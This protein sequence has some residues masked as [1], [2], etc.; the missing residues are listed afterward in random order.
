MIVNPKVSVIMPSLNSISY[1]KESINS[2][3]NQTL[4]EI[5]II[6]VDAGSTDGTYEFLK[7]CAEIDNRIKVMYSQKKSYGHQMNMA[8]DIASGEYI[9]IVETD[10]FIQANMYEYLYKMA[11]DN[12][13]DFIKAD[14]YRF[15]I[16][17][18]GSMNK[19]LQH[20]YV[21]KV[22]YN[23]VIKPSEEMVTFRFIMNTWSGIY[24]RKFLQDNMIRHNDT[25]GASFQD[26]GFWFQTFVLAERAYFVDQPFYM[27]RRDNP[28][29]SVYS[30]DKVYCICDEYNY[31]RKF[32][33][34]DKKLMDKFKYVFSY[35]CYQNYINNVN[36]ISDEYKLDF[37]KRFSS[38]F[39]FMYDNDELDYRMF[40][41]SEWE[42]LAYI[43]NNPNEYFNAIIQAKGELLETLRGFSN[44]IIYGIG[45]V[46]RRVLDDIERELKSVNIV[47]F[48][49]SNKDGNMEEYKGIPINSIYDLNEYNKTCAVLVAT[50]KKYHKEIVAILNN[51][52]FEH[53]FLMTEL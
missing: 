17:D 46:G 48:A 39:K 18:N 15:T 27:N 14:F 40:H 29:S 10:D 28:N 1:I 4:K 6:C 26:N 37:I 23:R 41:E 47:S 42:T 38:D 52:L 51:L 16:R 32:L 9:G 8:L 25:P 50:T 20:L 19:S 24:H 7:E 21:D 31:I 53:I 12:S 34:K 33:E 49:V 30:K 2:V 35:T 13:L 5:E 36:R 22:Y 43:I 44:V 11:K 3:I 45:V